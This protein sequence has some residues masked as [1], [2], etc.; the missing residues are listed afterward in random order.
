M[1]EHHLKLKND[2]LDG[3]EEEE[4]LDNSR[5]HSENP[6]LSQHTIMN[7]RHESYKSN[8]SQ[9]EEMKDDASDIV[10]L[11]R[12]K[13]IKPAMM[14]AVFHIITKIDLLAQEGLEDQID[15]ARALSSEGVI[16]RYFFVSAK[17]RDSDEN[18]VKEMLEA[19]NDRRLD[20]MREEQE[21][22]D[23]MRAVSQKSK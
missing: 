7:L 8:H 21:E 14:P 13:Q 3:D 22:K 4:R 19:I 1:P 18:G 11:Y 5:L 12:K 20:M 6:G 9:R 10:N 15:R 16:D 17:G 23:S 2:H